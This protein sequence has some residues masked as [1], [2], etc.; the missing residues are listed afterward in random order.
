MRALFPLCV[1][2]ALG[3]LLPACDDG[4]SPN[5]DPDAGPD[6]DEPPPCFMG[7]PTT[8]EE[9]INA[10][11]TGTVEKFNKRTTLPLVGSDGML[12]PL[13]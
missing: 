6:A 3:A 5:G 2:V 11:T 10:C 4:G 7:T 1:A 13:P 9:L 8:H 12:P